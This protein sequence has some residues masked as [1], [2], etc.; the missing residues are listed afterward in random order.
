MRRLITI[1][2]AL[3]FIHACAA[4]KIA[5]RPRPNLAKLSPGD[6]PDFTDVKDPAGLARAVG[7]SME[8]LSRLPQSKTLVFGDAH[9]TVPEQMD[10]LERFREFLQSGPSS[11]LVDEYVR[12][13]FDVYIAA[14]A[15]GDAFF[16]GYYTPEIKVSGTRGGV[17][18]FPLYALPGDIVTADLGLFR[19]GLKGEKITGRVS[20]KSFVPYF[21]RDEIETGALS[22]RGLEAAWC[23]D[24]VDIFFMQVQGSGV[25]V[26]EDGERKNANYA[27]AN[28]RPYRS[29]GKLL[30]DQGRS[31]KDEMSLDFLKNY[32]K[33]HPEESKA[34]MDYNES[35][36]FFRVEDDG[37]YGCLGVPVTDERTI[38]TDKRLYPPGALAFIDTEAPLPLSGGGV[39]WGPYRGFVMDQDSGGAIKGPSRADIYFGSG[40]RAAFRAGY[41]MRK[42][43]LYFLA[44]KKGVTSPR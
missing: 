41:M 11:R 21:T 26:Y 2:L 32:L 40:E 18:R 22:G 42:G 6:Y 35:Y 44:G 7:H 27:G 29:I 37:P 15:D 24:P 34:V 23:A 30:I 33:A 9:Y 28:G 17:Y 38:A 36:V 1:L 16:T 43:R 25:L 31:G 13:S 10:S 5:T 20:G 39:G 14:G 19:D 4:P 12:G 8:Y 3:S